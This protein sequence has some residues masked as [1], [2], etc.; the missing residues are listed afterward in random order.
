MTEALG[1][2]LRQLALR[3]GR[4]KG[5]LSRAARDGR[6]PRLSDGTFDEAAVRSA[7][8]REALT[9][10]VDEK[11]SQRPVVNALDP[12]VPA[13]ETA[14]L[15]RRVLAE[16]GQDIGSDDLTLTHVRMAVGILKA[17]EQAV[18]N[19]KL[20]GDLV[21]L[22]I[23]MEVIGQGLD[24]VRTR[25]LAIP[26]KVAPMVAIETSAAAVRAIVADAVN[27]ALHEISGPAFGIGGAAE[28][29]DENI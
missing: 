6:I 17:R 11:A 23:V 9:A 22:P 16:E 27:E 1:I 28:G 14:S 3:L 18:E 19:A 2:S 29:D 20:A 24:A 21:E 10:P 15:V 13:A 4:D 8:D 12:Q 25:L 5:G 26:S 7:L